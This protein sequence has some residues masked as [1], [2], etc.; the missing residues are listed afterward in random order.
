MSKFMGKCSH[1]IDGCISKIAFARNINVSAHFSRFE[2]LIHPAHINNIVHLVIRCRTSK[3]QA[4]KSSIA[5]FCIRI[6][7]RQLSSI[8]G[9]IQYGFHDIH[10]ISAGRPII[11][12]RSNNLKRGFKDTAGLPSIIIPDTSKMR[13]VA[14]T[15][16]I[17]HPLKIFRIRIRP[18]F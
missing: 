13:V 8:I 7:W 4:Y 16:F 6:Q 11:I 10:I 17:Q 3:N 14:V 2:I 9:S 5:I 18:G 1:A 12:I 15:R